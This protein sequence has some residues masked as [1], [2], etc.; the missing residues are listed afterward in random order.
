MIVLHRSNSCMAW[1]WWVLACAL[2]PLYVYATQ[3]TKVVEQQGRAITCRNPPG[4]QCHPRI[5]HV[6]ERNSQMAVDF[7]TIGRYNSLAS[8]GRENVSTQH[9]TGQAN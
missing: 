7:A 2:E 8:E 5:Q 4:R 1:L 6:I 9:V 3:K